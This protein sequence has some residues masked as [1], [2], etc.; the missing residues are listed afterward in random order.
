LL[1]FYFAVLLALLASPV[2]AQRTPFTVSLAA[3]ATIEMT[4]TVVPAGTTL[5]VE[6][7]CTA[8]ACLVAVDGGHRMIDKNLLVY[9][10][11]N[12]GEVAARE[13]AEIDARLAAK[14]EAADRLASVG[15]IVSPD[16]RLEG[17][18]YMG[19]ACRVDIASSIKAAIGRNVVSTA[20][21]GS[22]M[23]GARDR[24][25]APENRGLLRRITVLWDGSQNGYRTAESY[26]DQVAEGIA[27]LEHDRFIIIP[28]A[29]PAGSSNPTQQLAIA[30]EF[31]RRWPDNYLDWRSFIPNTDGVINA[32]QM[33]DQVHLA[34]PALDAMGDGIASFVRQRGW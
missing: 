30:D 13:Q 15:P 17:D 21:G 32:D 9:N 19:G 16:I 22:E 27:A 2:Y 25:L 1:K 3:D 26:A 34:K 8:D 23:A 7:G 20:V 14:A 10:G 5:T 12:M 33:C 6:L 18:S 4:G 11:E 31:K 29:V 24:L 28:A